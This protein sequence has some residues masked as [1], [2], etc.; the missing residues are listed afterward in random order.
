MWSQNLT[1]TQRHTGP[2]EDWE[3]SSYILSLKKKSLHPRKAGPLP[4]DMHSHQGPESKEANVNNVLF[5]LE[6]Y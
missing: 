3:S 5:S 1:R 6:K 2:L 4:K